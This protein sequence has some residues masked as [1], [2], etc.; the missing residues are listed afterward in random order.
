MPH[1]D[2][3]R[4]TDLPGGWD[5]L[6]T[7]ERFPSSNAWGFPEVLPLA[8]TINPTWP[9]LSYAARDD[10]GHRQE[11]SIA[12]GF[13]DDYRLERIW[14]RPRAAL[15]RIRR[16]RAALAPDLSIYRDWPLVCNLWNTYRARWI[17]AY[18][19]HHGVNVIPVA[20]WSDAASY[21]WSF[22]GLPRRSMIAIAVPGHRDR[23]TRTLFADGYLAMLDLLDPTIV[24][25]YGALPFRSSRAIEHP[26]DLMALRRLNERHRRTPAAATARG[27]KASARP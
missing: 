17:A 1:A 25:V 26:Q 2:G 27:C 8:A 11:R 15:T 19:Q 4:W 16:F 7:R 5:A 18:W 14:N 22:A 12:H 13:L 3:A 24:L 23:L 20:N 10:R 21:R 9:L 6:H